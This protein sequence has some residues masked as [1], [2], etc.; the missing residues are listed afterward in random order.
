MLA[1][2]SSGREIGLA[3]ESFAVH[4][5]KASTGVAH[6]PVIDPSPVAELF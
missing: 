6:R 3:P 2:L 4:A 5:A 1:R